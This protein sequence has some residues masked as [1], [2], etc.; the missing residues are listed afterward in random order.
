MDE[1]SSPIVPYWTARQVVVGTLFVVTV[2]LGFW[3]LYE[4]RLVI[5]ILFVAAFL[6]TAIRPAVDWLFRRNIPRPVGVIAIYL[7]LL[8]FIAG[9][10]ILIFPLLA[11]QLAQISLDVPAYY[12]DLR[13]RL[14]QSPSRLSQQIGLRLPIQLFSLF[15]EAPTEE[16]A[17]DRVAASFTVVGVFLRGILI[18]GA[19]F[20]LGFYWTLESERTMRN[21]LLFF[22]PTRRERIRGLI[23]E[24]ESRLG[25]YIRGQVLLSLSIFILAAISYLLIGLQFPL[26]LAIIAGIMEVVPILGPVL[27]AIPAI[28]V[29][30]SQDP[31]KVI[32]VIL[33]TVVMQSLENYLLVPRI[34]KRSVGV[35]PIVTLLALAAFTSLLGLPGALLAV[36]IAAI[37]QLLLDRF[38][39]QANNQEEVVPSGRDQV[40]LLRYEAQDLAL[41]VRKQLRHKEDLTDEETDRFEDDI[42]A[43]AVDLDKILSVIDGEGAA[44]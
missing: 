30:L 21:L 16:E 3:L 41:D 6:G 31:T 5:F 17:F 22:S 14:V 18:A 39:L 15:P 7:L 12:Q 42:E 35:N 23:T 40:S 4:F 10:V 37:I 9:F 34:M 25:G 26:V 11:E 29:A 27:G 33:A 44:R 28:L 20:L 2:L 8:L 13:T 1:P 36:P 19:I 24:I 43:I 38:V 32:L